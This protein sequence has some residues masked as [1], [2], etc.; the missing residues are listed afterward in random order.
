MPKWYKCA[1]IPPPCCPWLLLERLPS[2]S[3][4]LPYSVML[5]H[6]NVLEEQFAVHKLL[7]CGRHYVIG[8]TT[9]IRVI[10]DSDRYTTCAS[11]FLFFLS[12]S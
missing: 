6:V 3:L 4:A 9:P 8:R 10:H 7:G 11:S 5:M 12:G 1:F 2:D